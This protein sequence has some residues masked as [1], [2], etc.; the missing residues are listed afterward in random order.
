MKRFSLALAALPVLFLVSL[1]QAQSDDVDLNKIVVTPSRIEQ[2]SGDVARDVDVVTSKDIERSQ[3]TDVSEVIGK[4]TSVN[5]STYGGPGASKT[6]TMRGSTAAQVL[7]MVDG[8]PIN[9]PRDGQIDLN[10]IPLENISRIEIMHGPSSNLYGS[11]GMGGAIN[12]ITKEPPKEKQKTEITSSFG[13][14]RTYVERLTHGARIANFGYLISGDYESSEGFRPNSQFNAKDFNTK[15]EYK[16]NSS[17]NIKL[18]SGFYKSKLGTPGPVIS[19]DPDDKLG[20]IKNFLSFNWD[21]KQFNIT[22]KLKMGLSARVDSYSNFGAQLNPSFNVLYKF[23]DDNNV[24]CVI[25]RSFRAPTFNDLYYPATSMGKGNPNLKPER[26]AT[27]EIGFETKPFKFLSSGITY[28]RS[29]YS[30]LIKWAS[31]AANVPPTPQNISKAVIHGIEFSN[32]VYLPYNF[33]FDTG[34]TYLR[35][36]DDK[37]HKFLT[38][39]PQHKVDFGLKYKGS[40]GFQAGITGQFTGLRYDNVTNTIKVK[41]FFVFGMNLSKKFKNGITYLFSIDNFTNRNYQVI[42]S[43][44]MPGLAVTSSLKYEF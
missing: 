3:A 6:V 4:F 7:V 34:Y 30:Q 14:R 15:F 37:T 22:Q 1:G 21:F 10:T 35:A 16:L 31:D 8:R 36:M 18:N 17:N 32:A 5:I 23:N 9:N 24:H 39:Q 40:N 19:F 29:N 13:T 20:T 44:P 42:R 27:A 43:Y 12:I 33:E 28:Y 11:Q 2:Y 26:G 25:S 38:Y 41:Q